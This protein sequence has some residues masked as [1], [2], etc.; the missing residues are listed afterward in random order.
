MSEALLFAEHGGEHVLNVKNNFCT[1]HVLP[2]FELGIFM[3]W[4]CNSMNNLS[5]YCGLVDAKIRAS[6]KDSPVFP[7]FL[8]MCLVSQEVL[9]QNIYFFTNIWFFF[10]KYIYF[11]LQLSKNSFD[12]FEKKFWAIEICCNKW[13][14]W[15]WGRFCDLF[16]KV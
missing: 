12:I 5:S 4:T 16:R 9:T 15:N 2:R 14:D 1:Q 10:Y 8:K 11:F 6:D 3:Y 7:N 13:F